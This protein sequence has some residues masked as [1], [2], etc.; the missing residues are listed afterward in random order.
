MCVQLDSWHLER[1]ELQEQAKPGNHET[2]RHDGERS[3]YPREQRTFCGEKCS[4]I[5][6]GYRHSDN[7][8][9]A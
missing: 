8:R 1:H 3:P 4:W 6:L 7:S 9:F 2:E 5:G